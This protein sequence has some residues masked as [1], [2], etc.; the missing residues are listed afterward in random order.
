M[1]IK[2]YQ[3]FTDEQAREDFAKVEQIVDAEGRAVIYVNGAPKYVVM[4]LATEGQFLDLTD[5][6]KIDI[7]AKRVLNRHMEAFKMLAK[8]PDDP[9][10]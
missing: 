7:V 6:E 9:D 5:D 3:A 1:D 8:G 4:D 10:E 2:R